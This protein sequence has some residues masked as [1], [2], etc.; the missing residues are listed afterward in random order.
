MGGIL[1]EK[2]IR[3]FLKN[4]DNAGAFDFTQICGDKLDKALLESPREAVEFYNGTMRGCNRFQP[5]ISF[6]CPET[7]RNSYF[8]DLLKMEFELRELF[9]QGPNL[10]DKPT[11][12]QNDIFQGLS[13][14][15]TVFVNCF[16]TTERMLAFL[17]YLKV[18]LQKNARLGDGVKYAVLVAERKSQKKIETVAKR[19][20]VLGHLKLLWIDKTGKLYRIGSKGDARDSGIW[21]PPAPGKE[22]LEWLIIDNVELTVQKIVIL[23]RIIARVERDFRSRADAHSGD[24]AQAGSLSVTISGFY[25]RENL[26]AIRRFLGLE[27]PK[28]V[29]QKGY[30]EELGYSTRKR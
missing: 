9:R 25:E 10:G 26:D 18:T 29:L 1:H 14:N 12:A 16:C 17:V 30:S 8:S 20:G 11:Q 4:I 21:S 6:D 22:Q 19:V 2:K 28:A 13:L 15:S 7:R 3:N 5:E 24:R 27:R 23:R